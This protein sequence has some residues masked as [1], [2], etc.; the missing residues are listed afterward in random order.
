MSCNPFFLPSF[1]LACLPACL[2]SCLLA[3]LP[4]C[5]TA[6]SRPQWAVSDLN[7]KLQM[8]VS[9]LGP[10]ATTSAQPQTHDHKHTI[11]NTTTVTTTN[12]TTKRQPQQYDYIPVCVA[13]CVAGAH[14][15]ALL[16]ANWRPWRRIPNTK[17]T[18]PNARTHE[19]SR[20]PQNPGP[21]QHAPHHGMKT[22]D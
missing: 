5:P 15:V 7:C 10:T 16:H 20:K 1:L 3:C 19:Q 9:S 13:I 4:S 21:W 14:R 2:P 12:T 17:R 11:A 22:N 6:S 18:V 8:A